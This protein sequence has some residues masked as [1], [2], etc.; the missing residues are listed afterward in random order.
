MLPYFFWRLH[1]GPGVVE[2]RRWRGV[3]EFMWFEV[4]N[5]VGLWVFVTRP[6]EW[7]SEPG[8]VQ[9]FIW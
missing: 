7:E 2:K 3:L 5:L 1:L 6:F 9:R 4:V 8:R